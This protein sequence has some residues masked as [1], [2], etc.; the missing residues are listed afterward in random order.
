M[1][2]I[3]AIFVGAVLLLVAMFIV[4]VMIA[5]FYRKVEQGKALIV[6]KLKAE[7]EVTFT[8]ATVLPVIH[9]VEVM[10]ISVKTIEIDRRH[11]DG[12]ICRDNIRADIKVTFFVRV[13]K[14][15]EDVIK[16]AQAIGCARASD[17]QTLEALF[18]AKFSEGLKTVGK[19]LD[20]VDLYTKR[21]EFRDAIINLIGRDLNG[22]VLEDAAIDYLEQTPI[23]SLDPM[24]I[25]DAQ[26]IRK[27]T[28][29]T[30]A[31]HVRTNE[32]QNTERKLTK[33]QDVEAA[34]AILELDRQQQEAIAKQQREVESVRAREIQAEE[35]LRSETARIAT[36]EQVAVSEQNKQRQ[37]QVAEK[38]R[39]RVI[40]I[41]TERVEKDRTLEAVIRE[42]AVELSRIEKEKALEVERK[43]I[44][45]VIRERVAVERGVVE[46]QERIKTVHVVEDA[47]RNRDAVIIAAEAEA[48]EKLVKDIKAAEAAEQ[49]S[50]HL[51][52]Q[53]VTAAEA[54][55]EASDREA[56]AKIRLAEGHQAEAAAEGLASAKVKEADAIATEKQGMAQVRVREAQAVVSQ[57]LGSAEASVLRD[58]ALAE[59]DG[60]REK[61]IGE[62]TG[63]S[64]K[65]A[66]MKELD[67]AS[68]EHEEF[69]L[70]IETE[71]MLGTAQI[72]ARQAVE[73]A[74]ASILG[75]ALENAKIDIVGG[76]GQFLDRIVNSVGMGK[77]VDHFI[78]E[79]ETA[80]AVLA[81]LGVKA[82]EQHADAVVPAATK[83]KVPVVRA[84]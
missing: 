66:A 5:K 70:R 69:R 11:K 74:K 79:S 21:H 14:T 30:A 18:S 82:P 16:V 47:K 32:F 80:Q 29:L 83:A 65:A 81:K 48:Q 62:A 23:V 52:K 12:L 25:L 36:D 20:F 59:A 38:N 8:G 78:G 10:D 63:I 1:D 84:D 35:R 15:V 13:N 2:L 43:A 19:Q 34:E 3:I 24:N 17:P 54:E 64:K 28:E 41:E 44:Q 51:A 45:E 61:L 26:G 31:E 27:I 55:L 46:E 58:K 37:I 6:N 56:R 72:H 22:Y 39:E 33:K 71:R 68:R 50:T 67:S 40:G 60:I 57:K 9:K 7:P 49:A 73:E 75:K 42:R 77:A 53:R 76:D 4:G